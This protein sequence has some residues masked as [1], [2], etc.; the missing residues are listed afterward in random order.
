[1]NDTNNNWQ[2]VLANPVVLIAMTILLSV[3]VLI[4]AAILGLDHGVLSSMARSEFAR[5]VITYLFAVVT[6]GTA[7]VLVVA[8]LTLD[9]DA[10]SKESFARAKEIFALLLG[11]FGTIVGFYFGSQVTEQAETSSLHV[12]RLL[13]AK[14]HVTSGESIK[15]T[16]AVSGGTS[17]YLYGIGIGVESAVKPEK[18][19]DEND[20]IV[21]EISAP[22]VKKDT[23]VPV[24]LKV[25][26]ATGRIFSVSDNVA[27]LPIK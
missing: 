20:W 15:I 27:V 12:T 14:Q 16:A 21:S 1:M 6:I 5:G 3:F 9:M 17:P 11:V 2:Q 8:A 25:K 26:D 19:V 22:E 4:G 24:Y 23:I 18:I 13:L 10:K 7:V